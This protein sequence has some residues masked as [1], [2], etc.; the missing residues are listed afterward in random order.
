MIRRMLLIA[1]LMTIVLAG[2]GTQSPTEAAVPTSTETQAVAATEPPASEVPV[3]QE[4][5]LIPDESGTLTAS[6]TDTPST[7]TTPTATRPP[8]DPN[9]TNSASFVADVTIP[10]NT[11]IV[12]GTPFTKTWRVSNTGTCIWA[13]DYTLTHY[14]D[15]AMGAP[16]SVPLPLTY[17]GQTA[18]ISVDLVAPNATGTR[19]GN[20]VIKNPAG[21]IMQINDDS[22]LW[23]IINV[24]ADPATA[25]PPPTTSGTAAPGATAAGSGTGLLTS[26]CAFSSEPENITDTLEAINKYRADNGLPPYRI[27][28]QLARAAQSHANDMACN[29]LFG[30][31]GSNGST[32]QSRVT[33]S[34]YVYS[35]TSENV[36]GS[37]PPLTGQGVVNWWINDKT[38]LRHGRNLVSDTFTEVGI[39]YSFFDNF[40]YYVLVFGTP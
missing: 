18:E 17:P 34:G 3:S 32:V 1:L 31:T 8:N 7:P 40:G 16:P 24:T 30:H 33:A 15:E 29:S 22:R 21:L 12:A 23:L 11:N 26:T 14:S 38:D 36:Y 27:N 28:S 9:C 37:Y 4:T 25:T 19:R 6:P 10:D 39:G 13:S 20:F 2:C 35:F 5:A